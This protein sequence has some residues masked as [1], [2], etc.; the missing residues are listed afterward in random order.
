MGKLRQFP[1]I[2]GAYADDALPFAHQETINYLPVSAERNGARFPAKL[3]M[4]PGMR[5]KAGIGT[6]PIRGMRDVEGTLYVV[7]GVRLYEMRPDG[8]SIDR[9]VGPS[10]ET[11]LIPG[12]GL[13]RMTHNQVVG[14]NQVVIATGSSGYVYTDEGAVAAGQPE[15][16]VGEEPPIEDPAPEPG[17]TF[18]GPAWVPLS[19][20]VGINGGYA[21]DGEYEIPQ[22]AVLGSDV[23]VDGDF[24]DPDSADGWRNKDGTALGDEWEVTDGAL[25]FLGGRGA[26]YYYDGWLSLP[27][28]PLPRYSVE[29]TAKLQTDAGVRAR[30]GVAWGIATAGTVPKYFDASTAAEYLTQDTVTHTYEPAITRAN[31]WGSSAYAIYNFLPVVEFVTESGEVGHGSV[32]DVTMTITEVAAPSSAVTVDHLDFDTGL[33]G[34]TL[35]SDPTGN[36][37]A[38]TVT[39]SGGEVSSTGVSEYFQEIHLICDDDL[40]ADF[41]IGRYFGVQGEVWCD[42]P[43]LVGVNTGNK[44]TAGG[45]TFGYALKRP[46][47]SYSLQYGGMLERGDW[48][49]RQVWMRMDSDSTSI[50]VGWSIHLCVM[51]AASPGYTAKVRYLA[52]SKTDAVID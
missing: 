44:I 3:A 27:I 52:V 41:E 45:V 43:T 10:G 29:V 19:N 42:D 1:I 11:V 21:D 12:T 7:S 14:G 22:P 40:T 32:D 33:A 17:E 6:G 35:Y 13:V 4:V 51:L 15:Y 20:T 48:T 18:I 31:A 16:P 34:W 37:Y 5:V 24:T 8:T 50:P 26:A 46:D 39:E 25:H 28:M 23:V 36:P 2:G 47:G 38:P 30:L 9:S 49:Q